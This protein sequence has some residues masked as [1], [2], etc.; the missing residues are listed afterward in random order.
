MF[1]L[2]FFQEPTKENLGVQTGLTGIEWQGT[3]F[4]EFPSREPWI[5]LIWESNGRWLNLGTPLGTGWN[6]TD[7]D[8]DWV[9]IDIEYPQPKD[10]VSVSVGLT[11]ILWVEV[12]E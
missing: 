4:V 11:N 2:L 6:P 9:A 8:I 3:E 10:S 12:R 5:D 1:M 7:L